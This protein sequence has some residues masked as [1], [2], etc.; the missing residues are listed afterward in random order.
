MKVNKTIRGFDEAEELI[1]E[2]MQEENIDKKEMSENKSR[3]IPNGSQDLDF[4]LSKPRDKQETFI[5]SYIE[6]CK[7]YNLEIYSDDA[8]LYIA[9]LENGEEPIHPII[10]I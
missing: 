6:L 2:R 4:G 3:F 1:I 9:D 8:C 7:F 10:M 5:D